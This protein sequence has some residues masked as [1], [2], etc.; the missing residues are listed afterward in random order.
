[1]SVVVVSIRPRRLV[2]RGSVRAL[3]IAFDVEGD[4]ATLRRRVLAQWTARSRLLALGGRWLLLWPEARR[5]GAEASLGALLVEYGTTLSAAPL[6]AR[7]VEQLPGGPSSCCFVEGGQLV[8]LSLSEARELDP[9]EWIVPFRRVEAAPLAVDPP[10]PRTAL[11][12]RAATSREA[13]GNVVAESPAERAEVEAALTRPEG[14]RRGRAK[15]PAAW[16]TLLAALVGAARS[17]VG[18]RSRVGQGGVPRT[19][20]LA[21]SNLGLWRKLRDRVAGW[22]WRSR[23][24][25]W[26]GRR[27]AEYLGRMVEM[28]E[29]GDYAEALRYAIPTSKLPGGG[30]SVPSLLPGAP[31]DRLMLGGARATSAVGLGGEL[32][33]QLRALYRRAFQDLERRGRILEAAFVLSELLQD[34][35][36]AV[37]FLERNGLLVQ[38]AELAEARGLPSG[39]VV[40]QWFL[41]GDKERALLIARRDGV[42]EDAI[43]RLKGSPDEQRALRLLWADHLAESGRYAEAVLVLEQAGQG[44]S[45]RKAWLDLAIEGGGVAGARAL[46]L[47]CERFA[48][49]FDSVRAR[50]LALLSEDVVELASARVAFAQGLLSTSSPEAAALKRGAA[51]ALIRD[52]AR[53]WNRERRAFLQELAAKSAD[54]ALQA[55]LPILPNDDQ[56]AFGDECARH[57]LGEHDRGPSHIKDA[58]YLGDGR[59]LVAKGE[60]GCFLYSRA[61]KLVHHFDVPAHRLIISVHGNRVLSLAVRDDQTIVSQIDLAT[62][63][64]QRWLEAR[65]TAYSPTFDGNVWYVAWGRRVHALDTTKSGVSSIWQSGSAEDEIIAVAN[66]AKNLSFLTPSECWTHQLG[67]HRLTARTPVEGAMVIGPAGPAGHVTEN[68]TEAGVLVSFVGSGAMASPLPLGSREAITLE[69]PIAIGQWLVFVAHVFVEVPPATDVHVIDLR[70]GRRVALVRLVGSEEARAR[71]EAEVLTVCDEHGR[72]F[73]LDLGARAPLVDARL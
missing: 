70:T 48:E 47:K 33:E 62:R 3:G 49:E 24:G 17:L 19:S 5:I 32:F 6:T 38:A 35:H 53:G 26:L 22:L 65:L 7:E 4:E 68:P 10:P 20:A 56:L 1:M 61:R 43:A 54:G 67:P 25:A 44:A 8:K 34:D 63:R 11:P 52:R 41:V 2:H 71:I 16:R 72:V 27:H 46:A 18:G 66:D 9:S 69:R 45:L 21:R 40:R 57:V 51:R 31:R 15:A 29:R 60:S 39:L 36:A 37:D 23:V 30:A 42:F 58:V 14:Q 55:D 73:S 13:L 50:A 59:L 28:F 12:V 64:C